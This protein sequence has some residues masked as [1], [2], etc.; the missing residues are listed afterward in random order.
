MTSLLGKA[1][2]K[3]VPVA[4]DLDERSQYIVDGT[5][6]PCWSWAAHPEMYSGKHK[7]TGMNVQLACSITG[8]LAWISDPVNGSRHDSYCL[9][10]S[11]VLLTLNPGNWHGVKGYVGNEMITPFK[12]PSSGELLDWPKEFNRV[13]LFWS[14][15]RMKIFKVL[16]GRVPGLLVSCV[17]RGLLPVTFLVVSRPERKR[18]SPLQEYASLVPD[19]GEGP[20]AQSRAY[21]A[22]VEEWLA[23]DEAAGLR[24]ADL[25]EQLLGRGR[26]LLRRLHQDHLDLLAAREERRHDVTG[27]EGIARTLA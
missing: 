8:R 11:G 17:L 19:P 4:D 10:E 21:Y 5:L 24:H 14:E 26:E 27:P 1:L 9:N 25:E 13:W 6:L 16:R 15:R 3:Y 22:E 23:G 7:T 12:K 2:R 20:F 18:R